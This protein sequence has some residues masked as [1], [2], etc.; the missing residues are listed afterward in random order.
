MAAGT[1]GA[2]PRLPPTLPA[3]SEG[4]AAS[5]AIPP[6]PRA[7]ASGAGQ[8]VGGGDGRP[9][10]PIASRHRASPRRRPVPSGAGRGSRSAS[11]CSIA[12]LH[13]A[14]GAGAASPRCARC[15]RHLP[16]SRLPSP[17]S[18]PKSLVMSPVQ[19]QIL[20]GRLPGAQHRVPPRPSRL[21]PPHRALQPRVWSPPPPPPRPLPV[22]LALR[23]PSVSS[24]LPVGLLTAPTTLPG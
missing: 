3:V 5:A 1:A 13:S 18:S 23:P 2:V 20:S 6:P 4:W 17:S 15:S 24:R 21:R 10:W 16:P 7:P 8:E 14:P 19:F 9:V 22:L 12:S 11:A